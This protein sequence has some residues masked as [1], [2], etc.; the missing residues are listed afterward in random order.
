[1]THTSGSEFVKK[2]RERSLAQRADIFVASD[3][4]GSLLRERSTA[5]PS[6]KISDRHEPYQLKS[7]GI[8]H[9]MSRKEILKFML[10]RSFGNFLLLLS[11]YGVAATFGPAL[12]LEVQLR[13]SE[14]RGITYKIKEPTPRGFSPFEEKRLQ[15]S[16]GFADVLV[17]A[18]EQVLVPPDTRFSILIPKIG[19]TAKV[20]PNIDPLNEQEFLPILQQ[21]VAH[22][23]GTVFPGM[24]GGNI[25]LFAHST[26]NFW[27]VGRYNAIFYLIKELK[28][29]D[30]VVVYFE[31][32]RYN[33]KVEQSVIKDPD[34]VDLLVKSQIPGKEQLILQTCWPPGTTWKRLFVIARPE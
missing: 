34:D 32:R 25:Y 24:Q 27:N 18:R 5:T 4:N 29:G 11:L 22:A 10:I 21:G 23:K 2:S 8:K 17:G 12:Y 15:T 33:Y 6:Q 28:Q 16:P 26:D 7:S 9:T 20:Y 31:D 14:A 13:I 3:R 30:Q 19:A 1:M